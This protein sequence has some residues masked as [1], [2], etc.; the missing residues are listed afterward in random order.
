MVRGVNKI[1][2]WITVQCRVW[3]ICQWS[4]AIVTKQRVGLGSLL[5]DHHTL[6]V[7]SHS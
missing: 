6:Y 5:Y 1:C 2:A 3:D 4:I 7:D